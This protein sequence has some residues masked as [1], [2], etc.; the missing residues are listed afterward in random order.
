MSPNLLQ[1]IGERTSGG[2]GAIVA[3]ETRTVGS[4]GSWISVPPGN[5][6]STVKNRKLA[7]RSASDAVPR[8]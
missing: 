4:S 3:S 8:N 1:Q 5:A 2:P 7:L 6:D